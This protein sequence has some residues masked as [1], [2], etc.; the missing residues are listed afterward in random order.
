[1]RWIFVVSNFIASGLFLSAGVRAYI[2]WDGTWDAGVIP[3]FFAGWFLFSGLGFW[4]KN[5]WMVSMAWLALMATTL[6]C[7]FIFALGELQKNFGIS[8]A[9]QE[10]VL[11]GLGL[12]FFVTAGE[13]YALWTH[14]HRAAV[15]GGNEPR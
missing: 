12:I 13:I 15:S 1:M 14:R 4:Y 7:T 11:L 9:G 3:L 2:V 10:L 5:V 8:E 6:V